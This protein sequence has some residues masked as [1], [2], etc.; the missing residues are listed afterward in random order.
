[1]ALPGKK[2]PELKKKQG[3]N[4]SSDAPANPEE[5]S[6]AE[7]TF[8]DMK[9]QGMEL[10]ELREKHAKEQREKIKQQKLTE[11]P[12]KKKKGDKDDRIDIKDI[13]TEVEARK[14]G[15]PEHIAA[16]PKTHPI[17]TR[18]EKGFRQRE[19][20]T[21]Y[22]LS[23][24]EMLTDENIRL[25][26]EK[27]TALLILPLIV[28]GLLLVIGGNWYVEEVQDTRKAIFK[29][30]R[31]KE[32]PKNDPETKKKLKRARDSSWLPELQSLLK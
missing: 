25:S 18:W 26:E 29:T 2:Q 7:L 16:L 21:W 4:K 8:D 28:L 22:K 5:A 10:K 15:M 3:D 31:S 23:K 19:D 6:I 14:G 30:V 1:M 24:D 12:K 32:L 9:Q 13:E 17:R 20:G 27:Q 11:T